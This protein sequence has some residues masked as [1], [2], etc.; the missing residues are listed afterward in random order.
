MAERFLSDVIYK[1]ITAMHL[2]RL[3]KTFQRSCRGGPL[4]WESGI[5]SRVLCRG[6]KKKIQ[7]IGKRKF[8]WK[9]TFSLIYE[10]HC[11][12][13]AIRSRSLT[14]HE[15]GF[16][17][18]GGNSPK[19]WVGVC[20]TVL[21]SLTLF[22]TKIYDFSYPFSDL[23]P[24]LFPGIGFRLHSAPLEAV[25]MSLVDLKNLYSNPSRFPDFC[26]KSIAFFSPKVPVTN[27]WDTKIWNSP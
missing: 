15:R 10:S 11:L 20:R 12:Q 6:S 13:Q 25:W 4:A 1:R 19:F 14:A 24:N 21:K 2:A 18:R 16:R 17:P 7:M 26:V 3:S 27:G 8:P 23:T 22:Q 9:L 5:W